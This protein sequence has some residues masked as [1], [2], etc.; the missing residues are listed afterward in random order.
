MKRTVLFLTSFLSFLL[1]AN[2]MPDD[3]FSAPASQAVSI[4]AS[5]TP[6]STPEAEN[7]FNRSP[8]PLKSHRPG[9]ESVMR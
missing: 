2:G 3:N 6:E 1:P 4:E 7:K 8:V 9:M 5:P